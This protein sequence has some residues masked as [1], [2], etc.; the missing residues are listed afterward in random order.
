MPTWCQNIL[1]I[2]GPK[3]EVSR[4]LEAVCSDELDIIGQ[5]LVFDLSRV[6]PYPDELKPEAAQVKD[7]LDDLG[8]LAN[9]FVRWCIDHWSTK[10][11]TSNGRVHLRRRG[12]DVVFDTAWSAPWPVLYALV[13]NYPRLRFTLH[14]QLEYAK[15]AQFVDL[16]DQELNRTEIDTDTNHL[17]A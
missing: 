17:S 16:N 12:A 9:G 7:S 8:L 10:W 3:G 14:Y 5:P 6:I 1:H 15:R 2:R 13:D 4:V 11:N